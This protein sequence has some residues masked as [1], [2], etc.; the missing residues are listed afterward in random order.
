MTSKHILVIDDDRAVRDAFELA[1]ADEGYDFSACEGGLEGL[2]SAARRRPDL[3]FLDLKMPGID[4]VETLRRL[5]AFDSTI[6]VYI[7]TA[8][9]Q[10]FMVG[11]QQAKNEGMRF[12]LAAKPLTPEQ[13][14]MIASTATRFQ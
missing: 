5:H 4:G 1:L 8:F 3:V 6:R 10:E 12:Q 7:V 13:I 11:L 2:E 14:R 9:A